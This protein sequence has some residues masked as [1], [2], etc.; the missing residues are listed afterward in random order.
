MFTAFSREPIVRPPN[1]STNVTACRY[2][3]G[4]AVEEQL[5]LVAMRGGDI[6]G[7]LGV[8]GIVPV[9]D[10]VQVGLLVLHHAR[11]VEHLL[12][13]AHAVHLAAD[14]Q[15]VAALLAA[16]GVGIRQIDGGVGGPLGMRGIGVVD[17]VAHVAA[18]SAWRRRG[19]NVSEFQCQVSLDAADRPLWV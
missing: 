13:Q 2:A 3:E 6:D 8:G 15:D 17:P 14:A 5:D 18:R 19:Q 9:A 12:G 10:D 4:F 11:D 16:V 1:V 7:F